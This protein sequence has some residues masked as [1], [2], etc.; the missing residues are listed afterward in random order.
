MSGQLHASPALPT[1][2]AH[3]FTMNPSRIGSKADMDTGGNL[4]T[5][6]RLSNPQHDEMCENIKVHFLKK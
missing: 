1:E 5:T 3:H 6:P 4:T 2:K